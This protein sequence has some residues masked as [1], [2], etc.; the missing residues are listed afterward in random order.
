MI[1]KA[2]VLATE[3]TIS[4]LPEIEVNQVK[5]MEGKVYWAGGTAC[6]EHRGGRELEVSEEVKG[7]QGDWGCR[8]A[9]SVR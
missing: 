6:A 7:G 5:R 4:I 8:W 1:P 2:G 9:E 3:H